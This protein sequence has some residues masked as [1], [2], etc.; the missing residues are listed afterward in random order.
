P[1]T[2]D[3]LPLTVFLGMLITLAGISYLRK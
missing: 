2:G 1:K 3:K